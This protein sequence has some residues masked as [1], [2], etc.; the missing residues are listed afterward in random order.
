MEASVAVQSELQLQPRVITPTPTTRRGCN[1]AY[2][3]TVARF[4]ARPL[5]GRCSACAR[6]RQPLL[7]PCWCR[8]PLFS[9]PHLAKPDGTHKVGDWGDATG[10]TTTP[11]RVFGTPF[12]HAS[13][14]FR[15][16]SLTRI[17]TLV[18]N[19]ILKIPSHTSSKFT[20]NCNR[21]FFRLNC[22]RV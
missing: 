18:S 16:S 17:I 6:M 14:S 8:S 15:F 4:S 13:R 3:R 21:V 7:K 11:L 20:L 19:G 2:D 10:R 12:A 22:N 1:R 5:R 9:L